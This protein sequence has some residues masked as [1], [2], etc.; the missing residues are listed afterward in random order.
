MSE[1][2]DRAPASRL[3]WVLALVG[4]FIFV[5][6]VVALSGPGRIDI[7]D[8]QTRYEVARSFVDYGDVVV[9]NPEVTFCVLP[10]RDGQRYSCYRLPQSVAGVFALW[11]ADATGPRSQLRRHFFFSLTSAV[12]CG[13]LATFYALWFRRLGHRPA[14]AIGW[15]LAGVFCTPNWFYG[16]SVF[17]DI[18]GTTAVVMA[19]TLAWYGRESKPRLFAWLAGLAVGLAFNCKQPL[20]LFVLPVLALTV[21]AG[22]AWRPRLSRM[23]LVLAGLGVGL[24]VYEGYEWYKF[25]PGSTADH[26]RLLADYVPVFMSDP[27]PGAL[28]QILSPSAGAFWYCPPLLLSLIGLPIWLRRY[29]LFTW[30][31]CLACAGFF[32]FVSFLVFFKGDPAWGPRYLTPIFAALWVFVPT[33]AALSRRRAAWLLSLGVFVQLLALSVD[34]HRLYAE[35]RFSSTFYWGYP[36]IYFYPQAAHL[37]NRPREIVEIARDDGQGAEVFSPASV[38]T[39]AP[40][41]LHHMERG[42]AAVRKYHFL[43]SFRPWWASM[44]FLA[45]NNRPVDLGRSAALLLALAASGLA[46]L[47][48]GCGCR[49][50]AASARPSQAPSTSAATPP[51]QEAIDCVRSFE[52]PASAKRR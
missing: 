35:L 15:A 8:G 41:L 27:L 34:A 6:A 39:D 36:W 30:A 45:P 40:P 21:Q 19:L 10:G 48:I 9:R 20:G 29:R 12:A 5:V 44:T 22:E 26:A 42:P 16:T 1:Q 46:L 3:G 13:I 7:I 50:G 24:L 33:A 14:A 51:S 25:P 17:D 52:L 18:L 4:Q 47:G 23:A 11:L 43:N 28:G 2:E 31:L 38:P 37:V 32:A 49:V